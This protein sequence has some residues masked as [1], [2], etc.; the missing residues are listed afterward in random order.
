VQSKPWPEKRSADP[1]ASSSQPGPRKTRFR[2]RMRKRR[3]EIGDMEVGDSP[4]LG[5]KQSTQGKRLGK[6]AQL[7]PKVGS[8]GNYDEHGPRTTEKGA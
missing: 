3:A 6:F 5:L 8:T 1:E 2:G 4:I 7:R